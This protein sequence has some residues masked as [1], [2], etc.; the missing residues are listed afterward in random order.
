MSVWLVIGLIGLGSYLFRISMVLL[1]DRFEL[2]DRMRTASAFVAPA[3]FA[4]LAVS[5]LATQVGGAE[6]LEALPVL[7]ALAAALA[8][9]YVTG[10]SYLALLVGMPVLWA[11]TAVMAA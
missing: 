8:A 2:P 5:G 10:K 9:V 6:A 4:A 3:A 1:I 7:G 11:L